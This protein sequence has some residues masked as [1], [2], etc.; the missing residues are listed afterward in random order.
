MISAGRSLPE[1]SVACPSVMTALNSS[2]IHQLLMD[3]ILLRL[4][5]GSLYLIQHS[6]LWWS[7]RREGRN[8]ARTQHSLVMGSG[9]FEVCRLPELE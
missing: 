8:W 9:G 1:P 3:W 7:V 2:L 5:F 6:E 4:T